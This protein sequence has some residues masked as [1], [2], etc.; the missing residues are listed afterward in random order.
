V[1]GFTDATSNSILTPAAAIS[2]SDSGACR[3]VD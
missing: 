3:A 2:D 1:F